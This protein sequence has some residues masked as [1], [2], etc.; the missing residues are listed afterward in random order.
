MAIQL[1]VLAAAMAAPPAE[2][3]PSAE[4]STPVMPITNA[5]SV[6]TDDLGRSLPGFDEVGPSRADRWVGLFYWQ[7]HGNERWWHDYNVTAFLADHPYFRNFEVHPQAGPDH[8]TW[9]WAEPLFGY[10]RSTDEWVIRKHLCM[11]ADAGVDFLF[12]DYTNGSVYDKEL[13]AILKVARELKSAGVAVPK[14][15][16]FFN[17]EPE[18]KIH[19]MYTEWYTKPEWAD[20]WFRF[21]GK[22][23][24]LGA[25]IANAGALRPGQDPALVPAIN[26]FFTFRP[27]WAFFDAA[28][29]PHKWRF[30]HGFNPKPAV[31][32][33][34][35]PEQ[36][37]VSKSTGGPIHNALQTGGASAVEGR[38]LTRADYSPQWTLPAM[39]RGPF[40][41]AHWANAEKSGA[42]ITLVTG[43]N[44]WKASVW[45]Q[46]GVPFLGMPI[47]PPYG[48]FVDEFNEEFNR[49]L[50]PMKNGY[51]DDYYWQFVSHMRRYKGMQRPAATSAAKTI[52]MD[53]TSDAWAD[54]T[55]RFIDPPNDTATRDA[56][57][58][59]PDP[60][61][62]RTVANDAERLALPLMHYTNDSARNDIHVAQVARD[63]R[64]VYFHVTTARPLSPRS[65]RQWMWLL[66]DAD[67][68]PATGWHGYDFLI[69]RT[70]GDAN[71]SIE[72]YDGPD[73]AWKH[74]ADA[75]LVVGEKEL[76]I[77]L[78]RT[79]FGREPLRFDFKWAD[80]LPPKPTVADFYTQ[81]DVAPNARFN[82]RYD[83]SHH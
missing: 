36:I 64:F 54:V 33:Q 40:F 38:T 42:P 18:W 19:H 23:L 11:F 59:A 35:R 60:A 46:K 39:A 6:A 27:T 69:N 4:Q 7:W 41:D 25:P 45:N 77:A 22:P 52:P 50:E 63:D 71:A 78:P 57:A 28:K 29:F 31:D 20:M 12:L 48:Y 53:G 67:Q 2:Q 83:A 79:L 10:Y 76:T 9:Y 14:L 32:E 5:D 72:R 24:L 81:G 74:V 80:H 51:F 82:F 56:D 34:G 73:F 17:H 13:T 68:N 66:I 44:E 58:T 75:K 55:P 70:G 26:A 1:T 65:D 21:R 37:I 43:W 62:I 15:T 16:F 3:A 30:N 8:P 61:A 49:D 47:V